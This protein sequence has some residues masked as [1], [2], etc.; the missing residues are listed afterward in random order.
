[1]ESFDI[2][3]MEKS[4]FSAIEMN[5]HSNPSVG[6]NGSL[7]SGKIRLGLIKKSDE[8]REESG[9]FIPFLFLKL[10]YNFQVLQLLKRDVLL[11][12]FVY[13]PPI[14]EDNNILPHL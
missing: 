1:M 3:K 12:I 6:R 11:Y 5:G 2:L 8:T 7:L 9:V 10:Q 14:R 4:Y 13:I